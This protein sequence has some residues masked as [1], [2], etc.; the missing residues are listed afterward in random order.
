MTGTCA[1][2]TTAW[3]RV[4]VHSWKGEMDSVITKPFHRWALAPLMWI[5]VAGYEAI[6]LDQIQSRT[7]LPIWFAFKNVSFESFCPSGILY[8]VCVLCTFLPSPPMQH[9]AGAWLHISSHPAVKCRKL[10]CCG[11]RFTIELVRVGHKHQHYK[12][13][14][15]GTDSG[16]SRISQPN[17]KFNTRHFP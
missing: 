4:L 12:M 13:N 15:R 7:F 6:I 17:V 14:I 8:G 9:S 1:S 5:L 10:L 3:S 2:W 16:I 11:F